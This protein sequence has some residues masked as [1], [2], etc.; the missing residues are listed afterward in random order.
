MLL[1]MN[2]IL[3]IKEIKKICEQVETNTNEIFDS[4]MKIAGI[5]ETMPSL[6]QN[7]E[8]KKICDLIQ[9]EEFI[10]LRKENDNVNMIKT[11]LLKTI[12]S[13]NELDNYYS[14]KKV[15]NG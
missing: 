1:C 14:T 5:I 6:F 9:N 2:N 4:I 7:E 10:K 13:Y 15:I 8:I 3:E 11:V 12:D